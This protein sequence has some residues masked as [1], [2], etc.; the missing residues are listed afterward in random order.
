MMRVTEDELDWDDDNRPEY[1]GRPFTG[2]CVEVATDGRL[3][4]LTTYVDGVPHGP[5]RFWVGD[6]L[7]GENFRRHGHLVG[8]QRQWHPTGT[9]KLEQEYS[10]DFVLRRYREWNEDGTL[11]KDWT[12]PGDG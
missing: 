8:I 5:Q 1:E 6:L 11:V 3:L 4:S 9:P 12:K 7:V 2:E 10:E